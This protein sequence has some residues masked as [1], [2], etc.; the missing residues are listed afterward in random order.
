MSGF[1]LENKQEKH[2]VRWLLADIVWHVKQQSSNG[3]HALN[4]LVSE[5]CAKMCVKNLTQVHTTH[6]F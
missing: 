1:T 2:R 3:C 5:T 4:S 6:M